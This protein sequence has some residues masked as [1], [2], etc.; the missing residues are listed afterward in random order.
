MQIKKVNKY[1]NKIKKI[2]KENK[3]KEGRKEEEEKSQQKNK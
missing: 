2:W 3:K 1:K